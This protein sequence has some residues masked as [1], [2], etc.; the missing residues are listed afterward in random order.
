M[1]PK[2]PIILKD[3]RPKTLLLGVYSPSNQFQNKEAY[4]EEFV[5]LVKTLGLGYD[6]TLFIKVRNLDHAHFLTKGKMEEVRKVCRENEIEEVICSE[7]LSSLQE[8]NF[9]DA[10]ECIVS[11]RERLILEIFKK[12]AHTAEGKLAIYPT[13]PKKIIWFIEIDQDK[14]EEGI[15]DF[16][17]PEIFWDANCPKEGFYQIKKGWLN[18]GDVL[19]KD[20]KQ[21]SIYQATYKDGQRF[22]HYALVW[23]YNE[24]KKEKESPSWFNQPTY[25]FDFYNPS[26]YQN[27]FPYAYQFPYQYPCPYQYQSL[28]Q[29]Q[30]PFQSTNLDPLSSQFPH[31]YSF[32]PYQNITA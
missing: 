21:S 31:I 20:M 2:E 3:L 18:R 11:D 30:Y 5:S 6:L 9:S 10:L 32:T 29:Y 16:D 19:V 26:W 23:S 12:A 28:Y 14:N 27:Q 25:I 17:Y 13:G 1:T 22:L 7:T 4:F 8:R 24:P 15:E